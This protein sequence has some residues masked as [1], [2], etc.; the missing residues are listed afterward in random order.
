MLGVKDQ[1]LEF[2]GTS[3]HYNKG[4]NDKNKNK[5]N[6]NNNNNKN[7]NKN[8]NKNNINTWRREKDMPLTHLH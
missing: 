6:H 4:N 2:R 7:K 3:N 8:K 1:G 5:N